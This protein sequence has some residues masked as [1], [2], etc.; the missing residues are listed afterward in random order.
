[1]YDLALIRERLKNAIAAENKAINAY[2]D[3]LEKENAMLDKKYA[4]YGAD[5]TKWEDKTQKG[6]VA[7][8]EI[9]RVKTEKL[10]DAKDETIKSLCAEIEVL[11]F[12]VATQQTSISQLQTTRRWEKLHPEILRANSLYFA[13]IEANL[14]K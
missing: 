9:N 8:L 2:N 7:F 12:I 5:R 3:E 1:M 11:H 10:L 4:R 14:T 13:D 6:F